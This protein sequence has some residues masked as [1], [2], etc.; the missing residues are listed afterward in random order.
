M[1]FLAGSLV[2]L[3][4]IAGLLWWQGQRLSDAVPRT[5]TVTVAETSAPSRSPSPPVA[6]T[7]GTTFAGVNLNEPPIAW[8]KQVSDTQLDAV[9]RA[10]SGP[11]P[12]P[13]MMALAQQGNAI[14]MTGVGRM[15]TRCLIVTVDVQ[16]YMLDRWHADLE[17]ASRKLRV[18]QRGSG[19]SAEVERAKRW[20]ASRQDR[21]DSASSQLRAC[22][23]ATRA[24]ALDGFDWYERARRMGYPLA[25]SM[26]L[27]RLDL[28][29]GRPKM[30]ARDPQRAMALRDRGRAYLD[31]MLRHCSREHLRL[32]A[33]YMPRLK[34]L[35][36]YHRYV[37]ARVKLGPDPSTLNAQA[38]ASKRD[39]SGPSELEQRLSGEMQ[40]AAQN[41]ADRMWAQCLNQ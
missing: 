38:L 16:R 37:L 17:E 6:E 11:D 36:V 22:E 4:I 21:V 32:Y 18:L 3:T 31:E 8:S 10:N 35:D 15:L 12:F 26:Y 29:F 30:V 19:S 40:L 13:A 14:A 41:A 27:E 7:A 9:R 20:V 25:V 34:D 33:I 1:K 5:Q 24:A 2:L 23:N 28:V 39:S